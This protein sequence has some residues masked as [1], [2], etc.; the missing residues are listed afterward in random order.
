MVP[1]RSLLKKNSLPD[2]MAK[3]ATCTPLMCRIVAGYSCELEAGALVCYR[4]D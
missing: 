3:G 1:L 2:D 4:L